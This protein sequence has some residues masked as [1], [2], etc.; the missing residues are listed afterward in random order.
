MSMSA[1]LGEEV[2]WK[3]SLRFAFRRFVPLT[4]VLLITLGGII[5]GV[6]LCIVPGIWLQ[7]IW[8]V[9]VPALLV[10]DLAPVE[11]LGRSKR[12]VDGRFWPVLGAITVGSLLASVVQ[13]A[14]VL[15]VLVLQFVGVSFLVTSLLNGA[16]QLIA[17]TVTVPFVAALSAVI[18]VDLRVR[19]EGFD[20]ELLA[21]GVGID[22]TPERVGAGPLA[23]VL[24]AGSTKGETTPMPA[25]PPGGW[26]AP[27]PP[28]GGWAP[29]GGGL[30]DGPGPV[31]GPGG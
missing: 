14:F 15:P 16:A 12:L 6:L 11:S 13:S 26:G 8:A 20:L 4:V 22:G 18:Y 7:G 10:E 23:S 24:T 21:R 17:V 25:P 29:V 2:D 9:A 3:E 27:Q 1:Y 19:K 30:E 31:P 28:A 5:G